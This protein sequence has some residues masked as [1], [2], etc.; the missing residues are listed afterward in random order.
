MPLNLFLFAC[1][2]IAHRVDLLK[3]NSSIFR[4]S[5]LIFHVFLMNYLLLNLMQIFL[6][7]TFAFLKHFQLQWF[8]FLNL[9]VCII[10]AIT[11]CNSS[12]HFVEFLCQLAVGFIENWRVYLYGNV[13]FFKLAAI[14]A[15]EFK[16]L[17]Y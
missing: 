9:P 5:I 17:N 12:S 15:H 11:F 7:L 16:L 8:G 3:L 13:I 2:V 10:I 1:Y 4:K 6:Q 14:T